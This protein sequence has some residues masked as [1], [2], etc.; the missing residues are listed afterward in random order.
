[1]NKTV[2]K[3]LQKVFVIHFYKVNAGFFLFCFVVLYGIVAPGMLISYHLSLI[4]GM[5]ESPSFLAFVILFW[6]LYTFKCIDFLFIQLNDPRNNFFFSLHTLSFQKQ[7][8]YLFY[9]HTFLYLPIWGYASIVAFI[10]A[11]QGLYGSM[12]VV[13]ICNIGM[14][15]GAT[16]LYWVRMQ[17]KVFVFSKYA[18]TTRVIFKKRLWMLPLWFIMKQRKQM[19]LITKIFTLLILYAFINLYESDQYDIRPLLLVMLM[20]A[21]SHCTVVLQIRQFEEVFLVFNRSLPI[22][23]PRRFLLTLLMFA[24]LLIP[25]LLFVWKAFPMHFNIADYPQL[26]FLPIST[27][28]FFYSLL[29]MNDIDTDGY[30]RIVFGVGTILF[31]IIL[32]NPGLLLFIFILGLS[33]LL[34]NAHFFTFEK[35]LT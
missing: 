29:F 28:T 9:V 31:F 18:L 4:Q 23:I 21:M 6:L 34:Y 17:K 20:V 33:Y 12:I 32:Y 5:I 16:Y 14:M 8:L 13:I 26:L 27:I 25:E 3:I 35:R 15:L 2:I 30:F 1:M 11:K 24:I 7:F 22:S 19:L 10:A